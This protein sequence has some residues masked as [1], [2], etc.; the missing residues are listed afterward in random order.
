MYCEVF[1][2]VR[3]QKAFTKVTMS[4]VTMRIFFRNFTTKC[5]IL[6]KGT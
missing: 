4:T 6:N 5:Q 1:I 2:V 3:F